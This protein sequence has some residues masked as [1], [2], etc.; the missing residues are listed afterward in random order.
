MA[1]K[2]ALKLVGQEG[3]VITEAGFG[4]DNGV[5][6]FFNIK[7]RYSQLKT[8]AVVLVATVRALKMHGGGPAVTP[9]APLKHEYLNENIPLVEAGCDSNLKK[10]VSFSKSILQKLLVKINRNNHI[11]IA[12][13]NNCSLSPSHH[14]Y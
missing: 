1:D 5:E 12:N 6:K 2:V 14:M 8:N 13:G 10:Q 11:R 3:Y 4:A 9:G 7:C